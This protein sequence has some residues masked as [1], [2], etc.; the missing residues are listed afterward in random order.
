MLKKKVNPLDQLDARRLETAASH[1]SYIYY[2]HH[3]WISLTRYEQWIIDNLRGRY[4]R[5]NISSLDENN[6]IVI[7]SCIG[8]ENPSD[9]TLFMIGCPEAV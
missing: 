4:F 2:P 6:K 7:R 3:S 1:L 5:G 9:K 8:F